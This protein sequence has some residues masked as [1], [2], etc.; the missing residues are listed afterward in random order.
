[1]AIAAAARAANAGRV[2][3][4][5]Q[6]RAY[7][8]PLPDKAELLAALADLAAAGYEGFET[9]YRSLSHSFSDPSA[10]RREIEARGVEMIG[11]HVGVGLFETAKISEEQQLVERV[12]KGVR[13]LGGKHIIVS[14]RRLPVT[15]DGRAEPDALATKA[16]ELAR[17][18]KRCK[19]LGVRLSFHN[20]THEVRNDAEEIRAVLA[21]TDP[22]LVSLLFDVGHVHH[23]E[24]DVAAFVREMH[25][26]LAGLHVR[27]VHGG[28]EVLIGTG[29]VDFA[30]LGAAVRDS[31]WSGWV[32]VEVN[33]RDDMSSEKLVRRAR[34]HLKKTMEI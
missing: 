24:V 20:H 7:G 1:M 16:R 10:M 32:I 22:E 31:G 30:R 2:R 17:A 34:G 23:N 25:P 8:S 14:G 9:N 4:G 26:R 28:D 12:A 33:R 11:L 27:D 3:V 6:T 13:D 29:D 19:E 5:C 18:G 21:E 15:A